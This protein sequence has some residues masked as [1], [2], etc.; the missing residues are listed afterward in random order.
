MK[1]SNGKFI[2]KSIEYYYKYLKSIKRIYFEAG[3]G[4]NIRIHRYQKQY[5]SACADGSCAGRHAKGTR[6]GNT[7]RAIPYLYKK[8]KIRYWLL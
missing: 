1:S 3:G 7:R 4:R 5:I 2:E 6:G 8:I